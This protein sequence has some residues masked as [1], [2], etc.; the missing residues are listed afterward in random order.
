MMFKYATTAEIETML[1]WVAPPPEPEPEPKPELSKAAKDQ[2]K[3]IFKQYDRDRSGSLTVSRAPAAPA[4]R[5]P[6]LP[7]R[8]LPTIA[9]L[10]V[11]EL[12]KALAN[13]GLDKDD[14]KGYFKEFDADENEE[15]SGEEFEKLMES[16][17]VFDDEP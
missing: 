6:R 1:E 13:T 16:T 12:L 15:I 11:N 10:Q 8:V 14:I 4:A 5:C 17:G 7:R 2:I 9:C 3:G